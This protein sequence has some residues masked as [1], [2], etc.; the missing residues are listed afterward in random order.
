MSGQLP[1][2][3]V[4][5]METAIKDLERFRREGTRTATAIGSSFQSADPVIRRSLNSI[6]TFN[7]TRA[8]IGG[9]TAS[10]AIAAKGFKEWAKVSDEAAASIN[11][12]STNVNKLFEEIGQDLDSSGGYDLLNS[13]PNIYRSLRDNYGVAATD[14]TA[15]LQGILGRNW[16]SFNEQRDN[17]RLTRQRDSEV[18]S[19]PGIIRMRDAEQIA[20]LRARGDE[21]GVAEAEFQAALAKIN[22]D[23]A[24]IR[25]G[26]E[27]AR[28]L[29][30]LYDTQEETARNKLIAVQDRILKGQ[31][32]EEESARR[33]AEAAKEKAEAELKAE[34]AKVRAARNSEQEYE[35]TLRQLMIEN[36]RLAGDEEGAKIAETRLQFD[37]QRYAIS[38]DTSIGTGARNSLIRRTDALEAGAIAA[39][40]GGSASPIQRS[41]QAPGFLSSGTY[42]QSLLSSAFAPAGASKPVEQAQLEEL[43]KIRVAVEGGGGATFN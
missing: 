25:P 43:R 36:Q 15:L 38:I 4:V 40:S 12:L 7:G 6:L 17:L 24:A 42:A 41:Y 23:R 21:L 3:I 28:E 31:M 33:T 1:I 13:I 2:D 20:A 19:R 39:I 5:R 37:R 35:F 9:V 34:A 29:N 16:D 22:A 10:V 30:S 18:A 8:V 14:P 32:A 27:N 11:N 26:A